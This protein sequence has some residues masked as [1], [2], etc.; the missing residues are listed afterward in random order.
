MWEVP[1]GVVAKCWIAIVV[2]MFELQ[3]RYNVQ[4]EPSYPSCNSIP[5]V[6]QQGRLWH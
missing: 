5:T 1:E 4:Y 3:S 2:S 6:L